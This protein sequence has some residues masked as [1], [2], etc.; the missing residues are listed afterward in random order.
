VTCFIRTWSRVPTRTH[1]APGDPSDLENR[2]IARPVSDAPRA[3]PTT[4]ETTIDRRGCVNTLRSWAH[5]PA[6]CKSAFHSGERN[7]H[8]ERFGGQS[9]NYRKSGCGPSRPSGDP[10][11]SWAA[12]FIQ[13][14]VSACSAAARSRP[15]RGTDGEERVI[16]ARILVRN[17]KA[18]RLDQAL[19]SFSFTQGSP[20]PRPSCLA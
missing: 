7:P 5:K 20:H 17:G 16:G 13:T 14:V 11:A 10:D 1:P 2:S 15:R 19:R 8:R 12:S 3:A 6:R 4:S 9:A 18:A